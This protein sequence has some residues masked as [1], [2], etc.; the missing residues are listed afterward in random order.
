ME[1]LG[2]VED[3]PKLPTQS[4]TNHWNSL[5]RTSALSF[6]CYYVKPLEA[7]WA[8]DIFFSLLQKEAICSLE[9]WPVVNRTLAKA[10]LGTLGRSR[11]QSSTVNCGKVY[12]FLAYLCFVMGL[13]WNYLLPTPPPS[14][15]PKS[16]WIVTVFQS[17]SLELLPWSNNFVS[18][19]KKAFQGGKKKKGKS[20]EI[21][22][23]SPHWGGSRGGFNFGAPSRSSSPLL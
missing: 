14:R 9:F 5:H 10:L 16:S 6:H 11:H 19:C 18:G 8:F 15:E 2:V 1:K 12:T 7:P 22:N 4:I 21:P 23:V 17:W 3:S 20:R 13:T